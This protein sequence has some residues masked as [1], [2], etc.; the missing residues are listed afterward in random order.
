MIATSHASAA[1]LSSEHSAFGQMP[2]GTAIEKYT[3][4]N[5]QGMQADIITYGAT[6]Q[7][8]QVPDRDGQLNDVVLGFDDLEGYR[9]GDAFFGAT[10]GRFGNRLADGR[11]S[12]DGKAYQVPQNDHGNSLHGGPQGFDKRVWKAEPLHDKNSVSLKLTYV[13]ADGEMGF[14]GTLKTEVIYS[15]N[16]R[17]ELTLRYRATTDKPTVLNLTNHSYFN[18]AG[19]GN[20]VLNQVATV[21][22]ARYTPVTEKLIPTGELA[23][24]AGTPMD[25]LKPVAFGKRIRD[26]HPQLKYAEPKQG[27]YDFNWVLDSA[28]DLNKLAAEVYEPQSGRVLQLYTSEPGVQLYTGNFLDGTVRGKGGKVYPHWGAFTL[29]T[30]HYP[31]SPNQPGFPSTRLNPGQVYSQTTV[32]RFGTR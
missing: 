4:R 17:N 9:N 29:E 8:L 10:I 23:P 7:A 12:L 25:F 32:F 3:L 26:E 6:L 5:S 21:H 31:D 27:G 20:E 22:A 16:E 11:F 24:V 19:P 1:G 28:G 18:L 13:S 14:P 30:Q 15:L 2:D